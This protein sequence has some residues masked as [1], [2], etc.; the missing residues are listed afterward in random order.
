MMTKKG[1]RRTKTDMNSFDESKIRRSTDGKFAH[2]PHAEGDVNLLAASKREKGAGQSEA[3]FTPDGNL[4]REDGP[5]ATW[6]G[7]SQAWYQNGELHREGG[8]PAITWADGTQEWW[9]NGERQSDPT[10][11]KPMAYTPLSLTP[12]EQVDYEYARNEHA[13][14]N[15]LTSLVTHP[16]PLVRGAVAS[17]PRTYENDLTTL[18]TDE[19]LI[20]R[21]NV[22]SHHKTTP[23]T[24]AVLVEDSDEIVRGEAIRNHNT[25]IEAVVI[26]HHADPSKKVRSAAYNRI[27]QS[28]I[29]NRN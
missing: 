11:P 5:A 15:R 17:N 7:G 10:P 13:N 3:W 29:P 9:E 16:H 24:L 1:V 27:V 4:H 22:A 2:K 28:T 21:A 12:G 14:P 23:E 18:S 8:Q 20:V 25:P 6:M 19:N 26:A